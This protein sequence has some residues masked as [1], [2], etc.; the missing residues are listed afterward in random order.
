MSDVYTSAGE[1]Y[2]IAAL[3]SALGTGAA[4]QSGTGT[5]AATKADTA[6][7]APVGTRTTGVT[8]SRPTPDVLRIVR[9]IEYTG[10]HAITEFGLFADGTTGPLLSRHVFP[11]VNVAAGG[12]IEATLEHEQQ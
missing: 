3:D 8:K 1:A 4:V 12:A 7:Q 9:R 2:V 5:A 10:A 6:L 11:V